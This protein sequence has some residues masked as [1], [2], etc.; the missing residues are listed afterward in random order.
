[1][2]RS[3]E[4]GRIRGTHD[5][6]R[7]VKIAC[8]HYYETWKRCRCRWSRSSMSRI[9]VRVSSS[10]KKRKKKKEKRKK[11][12][13]YS[14]FEAWTSV[15]NPVRACLTMHGLTMYGRAI[16]RSDAE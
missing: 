8:R 12:A 11:A 15:P 7:V 1:M 16:S 3:D 6:E 14:D 2:F 10:K 13:A 9:L 4:N 5:L